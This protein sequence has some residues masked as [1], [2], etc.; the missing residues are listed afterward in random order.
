MAMIESFTGQPSVDGRP[1]C[2]AS[3]LAAI[4]RPALDRL[5]I[6]DAYLTSWVLFIT[7]FFMVV[8]H[9]RVMLL[10]AT[11]LPCSEPEGVLLFNVAGV[12]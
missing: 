1:L 4:Q 11:R 3:V 2:S 7:Y 5:S 6:R 10:Q 8:E 12:T 9:A